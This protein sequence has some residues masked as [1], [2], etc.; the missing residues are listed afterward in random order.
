M[1]GVETEKN[2]VGNF[3][4]RGNNKFVVIGS[5]LLLMRVWFGI[6]EIYEKSNIINVGGKMKKDPAYSKNEIKY[7]DAKGDTI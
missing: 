5:Q 6:W 7:R 1:G 4:W 2:R 3:N